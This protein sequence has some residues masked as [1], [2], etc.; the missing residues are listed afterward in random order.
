MKTQFKMAA[1]VAAMSLSFGAQ[2]GVVDLFSTNQGQYVD[3]TP[4][5]TDT[6]LTITSGVGGSVSTG[7][8]DIIGGNRDM[9]VSLLTNGGVNTR[10]VS[11]GVN[12]GVMDFSVDTL[13]TGRGQIQW[14]GA[15]DQTSAIDFTGLGGVDLTEGGTLTDF[16]L[17]IIYADA[18]FNF[19]LTVYTDSTTWT[20]V[21]LVANQ[22]NSPVTTLIPF[23]AFTNPF[24]CGAVNPVPGVTLISCGAGGNA[25]MTNVGALVADIDRFGGTTSIDLTLDGA[26][27]VPEPSVLGL[28]GLGLLGMGVAFRRNKKQA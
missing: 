24:L 21:A 18:G 27:T 3:L 7:G 1:L 12:G 17:D 13:A 19:E 28:L 26:R 4:D 14:D 9:Y 6:G 22:H 8:T 25:D 10:D 23:S 16:A 2:A 20:K 5:G 15:T 11:M